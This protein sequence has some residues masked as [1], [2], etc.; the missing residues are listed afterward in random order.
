MLNIE[1]MT[2]GI[3]I[4]ERGH[5]LPSTELP[6]QKVLDK[7]L[8][9][10][11]AD[12]AEKAAAAKKIDEPQVASHLGEIA[13]ELHEIAE[14][15]EKPLDHIDPKD[16]YVAEAVHSTARLLDSPQAEERPITYGDFQKKIV[17]TD[18]GYTRSVKLS[19]DSPELK[20]KIEILESVLGTGMK[21]EVPADE[22]NLKIEEA[23]T[24]LGVKLR[25]VTDR[26][27]NIRLSVI[28]N[29]PSRMQPP[30]IR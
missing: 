25:E 2:E 14:V 4:T 7:G 1:S 27:G 23:P 29:S 5:D 8:H 19:L 16:S 20:E 10:R 22:R 15:G 9:D 3:V 11:T 26:E 12:N 28:K 24:N 30:V 21:H 13:R 17:T 6:S 18:G